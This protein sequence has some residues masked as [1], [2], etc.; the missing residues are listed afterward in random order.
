VPR[1]NTPPTDT[2][3]RRGFLKRLFAT[4]AAGGALA[5][6]ARADDRKSDVVRPFRVGDVRIADHVVGPLLYQAEDADYL[7]FDAH[8]TDRRGR[9]VGTGIAVVRLTECAA[10]RIR[11]D[12]DQDVC[13]WA[14]DPSDLDAAGTY[15]VNNSSWVRDV[16]E[17][18]PELA[19][20]AAL[21]HCVF[22][23]Q[24]THFECVL[25]RYDFT[26]YDGEFD[27]LLVHLGEEP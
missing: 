9:S 14:A 21:H 1:V 19:K 22:T 10:R 16:V 17:D 7:L 13:G 15:E 12:G 4:A 3:S 24:E 23:F 26:V 8:R 20:G 27:D 18:Q 25:A 2:D 5:A 11:V 6:P